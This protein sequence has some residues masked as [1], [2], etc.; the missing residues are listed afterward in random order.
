MMLIPV[1]ASTLCVA[2][3]PWT[4]EYLSPPEG[5]VLE[6]GGMGFMSDGDMVVSTRRGQVWR[7]Q[8][9]NAPHPEDATFTLI[10]EGLH[11]GLQPNQLQRQ[12]RRD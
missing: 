1:I 2:S 8:D 4:V 6:V 5:A 7:I 3:S 11:E 9:P 10:C 12:P